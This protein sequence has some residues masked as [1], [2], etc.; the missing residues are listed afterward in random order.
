[1]Q[2]LVMRLPQQCVLGEHDYTCNLFDRYAVVL[3]CDAICCVYVCMYDAICS[4]HYTCN[5]YTYVSLTRYD[6]A[7]YKVVS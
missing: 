3:R 5:A 1:M 6:F 2:Y 7:C 4:M